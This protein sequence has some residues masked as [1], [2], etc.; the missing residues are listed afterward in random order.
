MAIKS[1]GD[2]TKK[3]DAL[4]IGDRSELEGPYGRFN[5]HNENSD[6]I[7]VAGGIG[8][9]P[10]IGMAEDLAEKDELKNKVELYY[11]VKDER[12]FVYFDE[13]KDI[14]KRLKNNF[15]FIPWVTDTHGHLTIQEIK[16]LS[17]PFKRSEFYLCGPKGL[18]DAISKG[19]VEAGVPKEKIFDEQFNFR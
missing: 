7:W 3:L 13:F 18:K 11:C 15:K 5:F 2:F 4:K 14:E 6:Q 19:L 8:I 10:F 16:K 12:E 9:T 1:L 17:S